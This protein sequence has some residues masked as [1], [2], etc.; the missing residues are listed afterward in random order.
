MT[1]TRTT[2]RSVK[3]KTIHHVSCL[4]W[5]AVIACTGCQGSKQS[6]SKSGYIELNYTD[7][8]LT[9]PILKSGVGIETEIHTLFWTDSGDSILYVLERSED[10]K[11]DSP[12]VLYYGPRTSYNLGVPSAREVV[13]LQRP[14]IS[15]RVRAVRYPATSRW[16]NPVTP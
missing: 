2:P 12:E 6:T 15:Y 13:S 7:T 5:A 14:T 10:L 3:R 9:T 11:F 4:F 8:T 1:S 16:S